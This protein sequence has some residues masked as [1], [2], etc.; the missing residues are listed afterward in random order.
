[1]KWGTA[2]VEEEEELGVGQREG[3]E[4]RK[5]L[6]FREWPRP[7][8][9]RSDAHLLGWDWRLLNLHAAAVDEGMWKPLGYSC[10]TPLPFYTTECASRHP[11]LHEVFSTG[12]G[13]ELQ[14]LNPDDE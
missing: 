14:G 8:A 5:D 7:G 3:G 1:M 9:S 13:G 6:T 12:L 10:L 2:G 4:E 11:L